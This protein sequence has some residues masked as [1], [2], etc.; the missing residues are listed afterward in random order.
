MGINFT[1]F[2]NAKQAEPMPITQSPWADVFENVLKGYKIAEEPRKM[3]RE[4]EQKELANSLQKLALAHKPKEYALADSLKQ[5][6]IAKA[7]RPGGSG[8]KGALAT[9]FQLR[10][11]LDPNSP[12]YEKDL[13]S[14]NDYI[15]HLGN[16]T[17][18]GAVA[19]PG[20]GIKVD[21]PEGKVGYIPATGKNKAGWQTVTD[22][23]G[24]PIGYNVPRSDKD[25]TQLKA[26]AG[27]DVVYP[28]LN[29]SFGQYSGRGGYERYISDIHNYK[30]DAAAK[31]RI[32]N[33][34][35]AN[36]LLSIASTTE[37]AR[38]GGHATNVQLEE[39]KHSLESSEIGRRLKRA[40]EFGLPAK[41]SIPAGN[42]FKGYLDKVS[43]VGKVNIP[44]HEFRAINPGIPSASAPGHAPQAASKPEVLGSQNGVTAIKSQGKVYRIPDNLVEQFM[45]ENS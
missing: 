12:T 5:A 36:K 24:Q 6:Q 16:P 34:G 11:K 7:N 8:L 21:L 38:I 45:R 3:K 2:T 32:D 33:L 40:G 20:E 10:D 19:A 22:D 23:K 28:F 14:V 27:F 41:Y 30:K 15:T 17:G 35:A 26:K 31:S 25:I 4:A 1:D 9:A 42:I 18:I 13:K 39:L 37:N 43:D 44:S 29:E